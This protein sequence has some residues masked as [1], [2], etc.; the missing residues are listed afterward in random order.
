MKKILPYLFFLF[1]ILTHCA[2]PVAPEVFTLN[3]LNFNHYLAIGSDYTSGYTNDGLY[4]EGQKNSFPALIAQQ[5]RHINNI[6]FRQAFLETGMDYHYS[7]KSVSID[8]LCPSSLFKF[9]LDTTSGKPYSDWTD[10]SKSEPFHNLGIPYLKVTDINREYLQVPNSVTP[11]FYFQRLLSEKTTSYLDYIKAQPKPTFFSVEL[12]FNDVFAYVWKGGG[13]SI[14]ISSQEDFE[15]NYTDLLE[16]LCQNNAQGV[17]FTIP[18]VEDLPFVNTLGHQWVNKGNCQSMSLYEREDINGEV[19]PLMSGDYLLISAYNE[20][21][22]GSNPQLGI[23]RNY[24]LPS[25]AVLDRTEVQNA[26]DATHGFNTFIKKMAAEKNLALFDMEQFISDIRGGK[27]IFDGV[28]IHSAYINGGFYSLD[29]FTLT[30]RGNA[31]IANRVI[32][33]INAKY[34]SSIPLLDIEDY[35]GV[36]FPQRYN[37]LLQHHFP[38][39]AKSPIDW[40][41]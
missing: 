21:E 33:T 12:G 39:S 10:L 7:L 6:P 15:K 36:R 5:I 28:N 11:N 4:V 13:S 9:K 17:L 35:E 32:E 40:K 30:P 24:P 16:V 26:V 25:N 22:Y 31:I 41:K 27:V 19:S 38:V 20:M 34:E 2:P 1:V 37:C 23:N 14:T 29:G 3:E 8:S 18:S